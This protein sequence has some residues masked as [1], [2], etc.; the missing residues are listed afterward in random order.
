MQ[1]DQIVQLSTLLGK[2]LIA[3]QTSNRIDWG[4]IR[5]TSQLIRSK[6]K[7]GSYTVDEEF[8]DL[9]ETLRRVERDLRI[10]IKYTGD[11]SSTALKLID[12][13]LS[14]GITVQTLFDPYNGDAES[15]EKN[16]RS[17]ENI[18]F[19]IQVINNIKPKI[20]KE[21][22]LMTEVTTSKLTIILNHVKTIQKK[23]HL[24]NDALL[25]YDKSF[26]SHEKLLS[27]QK[28]GEL[29]LKQSQ[30]L[31]SIERKFQINKEKYE[32]LNGML[33]TELPYF[34]SLVSLT[35][36][37]ILLVIYYIQLMVVF[38]IDQNLQPLTQFFGGSDYEI[39]KEDFKSKT[40]NAGEAINNL[41]IINFRENFL[42]SLTIV[43]ESESKIALVDTSEHM[44]AK[45]KFDFAAQQP[46]DL[47]VFAGDIITLI[48]WEG[49]WWKG[50]L[51]NK[52]GIFPG[53]YVDIIS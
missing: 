14:I 44:Q 21:L 53:N 19:Y 25:E 23:I 49:N 12:I 36:R 42:R 1:A 30:Q 41:S 6:V 48:Q 52:I 15:F 47:T 39:M 35:F 37:N 11:F 50:E 43:P 8:D 34:F 33:K 29:S 10:V 26:N 46:G 22:A 18:N 38:Q 20:T 4:C 28:T 5:R 27:E 45:V 13:S 24:R 16:F 2:H 7:S 32:K 40:V 51:R 17:W 3:E 9:N 31:F